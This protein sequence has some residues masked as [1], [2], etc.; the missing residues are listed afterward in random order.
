[1]KRRDSGLIDMTPL[2]DVVFI[3]LFALILNV[4][5]TKAQDRVET[6]TREKALTTE[7]E[8]AESEAK[9]ALLELATLRDTLS[10]SE[11]E[12]V[13]IK[14]Q[15]ISTEEALEDLEEVARARAELLEAYAEA[16]SETL[17]K[18]VRLLEE[19]VPD[20]W[21]VS[22]L[23]AE[24]LIEEWLKYQQ[25]GER[26]LFADLKISSTDGRIYFEEVYTGVNIQVTSLSDPQLRRELKE[27]L[28]YYIYDWLDHKAGG[29]TFVF[30]S[31]ISDEEVKRAVVEVVFDSLQGLQTSFDKDSYLINRFVTYE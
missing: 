6:E 22:D 21:M 23:E 8:S 24:A 2:L 30:V 29:Y 28:Q 5:V 1:M 20:E 25:I 12:S 19:D 16:L 31:V 4:N 9:G 3:L 10:Q 17:N 7:L 13:D 26:Y 18:E 11:L 27:E 14:E 15:L